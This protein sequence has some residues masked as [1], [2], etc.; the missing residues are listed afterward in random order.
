ML[1]TAAGSLIVIVAG[2]ALLHRFFRRRSPL[3][4]QFGHGDQEEE[5]EEEEVNSREVWRILKRAPHTR[6]TRE[7]R[8]ISDWQRGQDPFEL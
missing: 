5:E 1:L 8:I 4:A 3:P 6:S 2:I 7:R